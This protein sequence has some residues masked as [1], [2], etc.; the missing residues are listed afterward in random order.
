MSACSSALGARRTSDEAAAWF[1]PTL[2]GPLSPPVRSACAFTSMRRSHDAV[3]SEADDVAR[4]IPIN[5][6]QLARVGGVAAP[7]GIETKGREL[8]CRRCKVPASGGQGHSDPASAEADDVGHAVPVNVRE[9][10]RV[11]V[12]AGPAAGAGAGTEGVKLESGGREV[13]ASGGEGHKDT[14]RAEADNV[15]H[16]VAVHVRERARVGVVA[17]PTAGVGTEGGKLERGG[18]KVPV[19]SGQRLED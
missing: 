13:P 10:A 2:H 11:E 17:A 3:R 14:V 19:A 4:S 6:G 7:S 15:G 9:R 1:D 5:V 18:H 16:V 12:L 8:E